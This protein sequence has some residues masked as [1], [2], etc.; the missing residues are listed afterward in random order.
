MET[1]LK[2]HPPVSAPPSKSVCL[3]LRLQLSKIALAPAMSAMRWGTRGTCPPTF[4]DGGDK[5]CHVPLHFSPLGFVFKEVSKIKV[6]FV[7]FG[8]KSFSC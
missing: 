3:Q 7:T 6:T 5:I 2:F 4:S 1:E 8:V